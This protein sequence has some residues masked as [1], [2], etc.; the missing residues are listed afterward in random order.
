MRGF[1]LF[2]RKETDVG[3]NVSN[4]VA[5]QTL[6]AQV[7]GVCFFNQPF[8]NRSSTSGAR[9]RGVYVAHNEGDKV[10]HKEAFKKM[11]VK[12]GEELAESANRNKVILHS[13]VVTCLAIHLDDSS[14]GTVVAYSHPVL[15]TA[16]KEEETQHYN[17][18]RV[19]SLLEGVRGACKMFGVNPDNVVPGLSAVLAAC[20]TTAPEDKR[21][22]ERV[23]EVELSVDEDDSDV[24]SQRL[25]TLSKHVPPVKF[26]KSEVN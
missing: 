1:L 8:W 25:A 16:F 9:T 12:I 7:A 2:P 15:P 24:L 5:T 3:D 26:R 6:V 19:R 4:R 18:E 23:R 13:A 22:V 10:N 17:E 21:T 20:D 11:L 14:P